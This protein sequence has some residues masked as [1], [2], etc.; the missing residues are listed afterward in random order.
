MGAATLTRALLRNYLESVRMPFDRFWRVL[1]AIVLASMSVAH[2]HSAEQRCGW[3]E[4]P[5]P[6]NISL[7]DKDGSWSITSQ[8]QANGKDAEGLENLP[9]LDEMGRVAT[10]RNGYGYACACLLVETNSAEKRV[11]KV[12]SSKALP[13][14]RC[15]SDKSLPKR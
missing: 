6:G 2:A 10:Q 8:M 15:T 1:P 9:D 11:V 13:L 5:T 3:Y 14:A 7:A 4:N 12:I